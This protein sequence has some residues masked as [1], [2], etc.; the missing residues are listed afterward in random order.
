MYSPYTDATVQRCQRCG[1][2]L[3]SQD[4]YCRNCGHVQ[5]NNAV[6]PSPSGM[7]WG[8]GTAQTAYGANQNGGQ[9]YSGQFSFNDSSGR[10]AAPQ[11]PFGP[12]FNYSFGGTAVPQQPFSPSSPNNFYA[13]STGG[14]P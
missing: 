6:A 8:E 13:A 11:Q 3:S 12:P 10:T 5:A 14:P 7:S 2:P 4:G 1:M 9:Q